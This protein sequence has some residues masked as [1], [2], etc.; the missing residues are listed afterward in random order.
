MIRYAIRRVPG[1][2]GFSWLPAL[3]VKA[4]RSSCRGHVRRFGVGRTPE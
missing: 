4:G 2:G 3:G 1:S